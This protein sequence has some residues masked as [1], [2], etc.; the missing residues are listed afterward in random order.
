[1]ARNWANP[2]SKGRI[3]MR[4]TTYLSLITV[5]RL[6]IVHNINMHITQND[7]ALVR[8][9]LPDDISKDDASFR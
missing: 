2:I 7:T 5:R 1:M 6:D 3:P 4:I 9:A 8:P